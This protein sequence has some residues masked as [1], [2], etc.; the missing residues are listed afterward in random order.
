MVVRVTM[1]AEIPCKNDFYKYRRW[2]APC[3]FYLDDAASTTG[4]E[5]GL[6]VMV[7]FFGT[8]CRVSQ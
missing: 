3:S 4:S 5:Y 6:N 8:Y 2:V 7:R 1:A